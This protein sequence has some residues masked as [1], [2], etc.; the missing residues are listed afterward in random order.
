[1]SFAFKYINDIRS[2]IIV[3]DNTGSKEISARVAW[4]RFAVE[5][6]RERKREREKWRRLRFIMKNAVADLSH[7]Y[8]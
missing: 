8:L 1:M 6:D 4:K 2:I 5:L 3:V 7:T